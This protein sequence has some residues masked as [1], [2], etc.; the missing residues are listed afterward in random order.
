MI[1]SSIS[2]TK[3]NLSKILDKVRQ[4][5]TVLVMDRRRPV[6]RIEPIHAASTVGDD[7]LS[8]LAA[9]GV[10][11]PPRRALDPERILSMPAARSLGGRSAVAAL[12]A[13]RE[14]SP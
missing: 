13:E 3:N 14:E 10:V 8:A 12:L 5:E 2:E 11:V 1:L 7:A 6:A 4:G 9:D